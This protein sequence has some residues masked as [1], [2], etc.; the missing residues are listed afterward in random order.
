MDDKTTTKLL[1]ESMKTPFYKEYFNK[2]K[3]ES[4]I[5][6]PTVDKKTIQ[7]NPSLFVNNEFN[8]NEMIIEKTSGSSGIP[9]TCYKTKSE[10][11]SLAC[12]LTGLR[13]EFD[14]GVDYSRFL[15][16]GGHQ[17]PLLKSSNEKMENLMLSARYINSSMLEYYWNRINTFSPTFIQGFPSILTEMALYALKKNIK[18]NLKNLTYLETRSENLSQYQVKIIEKVFERPVACHYGT[19]EVWTIAY[20]CRKGKLHLNE[21]NVYV[22]CEKAKG[23]SYESDMNELL[24]T[25]KVLY[26]MPFIRYRLGDVGKILNTC[27]CGS[28]KPVIQVDGRSN[29]IVHSVNGV[30]GRMVLSP[31]KAFLQSNSRIEQI[32]IEQNSINCFL[33]RVVGDIY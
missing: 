11:L 8:L 24:V 13:S 7:K 6:F 15:E 19:K 16:F 1:S 14:K 29:E 26:A 25:S 28:K 30:K 4:F 23:A 21:K 17:I 22:E 27:E 2:K 10:Q 31:L 33:I 18:I 12:Q 3:F 9:L 20:S 5:D 32:Q